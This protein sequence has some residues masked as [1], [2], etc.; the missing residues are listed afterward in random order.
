MKILVLVFALILPSCCKKCPPIP[1][2]PPPRTIQ[3]KVPCMEPLP[4][5]VVPVLPEPPEGATKVEIETIEL[6][7]LFVLIATLRSY[8]ETQL[9]RCQVK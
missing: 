5:L 8:L 2:A 3:I 7:K 1:P 4:E 6:R 9:T